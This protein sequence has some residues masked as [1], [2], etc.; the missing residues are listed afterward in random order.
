MKKLSVLLI[1]MLLV[2]S[3]AFAQ[4][5]KEAVA[6]KADAPFKVGVIYVSPPGDRGIPTCT[7][8]DQSSRSVFRG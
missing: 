4:G 1:L 3:M 5:G 2:T 8:R 6:P 7:T